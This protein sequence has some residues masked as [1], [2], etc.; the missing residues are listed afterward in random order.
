M[1]LYTVVNYI[2]LPYSPSRFLPNGLLIATTD[3]GPAW[4]PWLEFMENGGQTPRCASCKN[5]ANKPNHADCGHIFCYGC[6]KLLS[7]QAQKLK[8]PKTCPVCSGKLL[9]YSP[10]QPTTSKTKS[11]KRANTMDEALI[12]KEEREAKLR[13]EHW[14]L[15]GD[16]GKVAIP[17]SSKTMLIKAQILNWLDQDPDC[18]IV[19]FSEWRMMYDPSRQNFQF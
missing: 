7:D 2:L 1:I 9:P 6:L 11:K 17:P 3:V 19:L 13:L 10:Y 15:S 4:L 12:E 5:I 16:R 14:F 18:K 8:T